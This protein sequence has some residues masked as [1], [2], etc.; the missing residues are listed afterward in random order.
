MN[1]SAPHTKLFSGREEFLQVRKPPTEYLFKILTSEKKEKISILTTIFCL[2]DDSL[3]FDTDTL[4]CDNFQYNLI[5]FIN[6]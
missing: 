4:R 3:E 5:I 2:A 1:G 6:I